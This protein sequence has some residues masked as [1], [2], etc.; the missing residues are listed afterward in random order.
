M[1][2]KIRRQYMGTP[3]LATLSILVLTIAGCATS[4]IA[5]SKE[6]G[7]TVNPIRTKNISVKT[8]HVY[9]NGNDIEI[10]GIVKRDYFF[11]RLQY[12]HVDIAIYGPDGTIIRKITTSYTPQHSGGRRPR[13]SYYSVKLRQFMVP[14]GSVIEAA[15]HSGKPRS[16]YSGGT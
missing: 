12:G 15:Y 3:L 13:Q 7:V 16:E 2:A 4:R 10:S 11:R 6:R 14:P 9:Q 8:L 1:T 5:L